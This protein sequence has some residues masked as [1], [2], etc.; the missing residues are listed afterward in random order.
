MLALFRRLADSKPLSLENETSVMTHPSARSSSH[1]VEQ[2]DD[3]GAAILFSKAFHPS[4]LS[5]T[6]AVCGRQESL[7]ACSNDRDT[8]R[9]ECPGSE[10][11]NLCYEGSATDP[12]C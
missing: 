6:P 12:P 11:R 2:H 5:C 4:T 3:N 7:P 10:E 1:S 9:I 8:L